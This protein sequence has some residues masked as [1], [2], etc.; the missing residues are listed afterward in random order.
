MAS[1]RQKQA[2]AR[3]KRQ[4]DALLAKLTRPNTANWVDEGYS[5]LLAAQLYQKLD[6]ASGDGGRTRTLERIRRDFSYVCEERIGNRTRAWF[7]DN[8]TCRP[9]NVIISHLDYN[10]AGQ[11]KTYLDD[12]YS[13]IYLTKHG[14]ER[15][16]QRLRSNSLTDAVQL[17]KELTKLDKPKAIGEELTLKVSGGRFELISDALRIG[18]QISHFAYQLAPDAP[19]EQPVIIHVLDLDILTT[20][21]EIRTHLENARDSTTEPFWVVKTYV[22]DKK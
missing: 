8:S 13:P 17:I 21:G 10:G 18:D 3:A 1:T 6:A 2:E 20:A 19:P 14:L 12:E 22:A 9:G 5:K 16:Y 11:V 7:L 15:V 4:A